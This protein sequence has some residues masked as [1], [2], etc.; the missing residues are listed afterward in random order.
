M[1]N[2]KIGLNV[3]LAIGAHSVLSEQPENERE[4]ILQ[5]EI[6]QL[7][8]SHGIA[9]SRSSRRHYFQALYRTRWHK[10]NIG[11]MADICNN[12]GFQSITFRSLV[13][14]KNHLQIPIDVYEMTVTL[15]DER[16]YNKVGRIEGN[17]VLNVSLHA[18]YS[19][20]GHLFFKP[21]G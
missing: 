13:Q 5:V 4:L 9:V 6:P 8:Y 18:L 1:P 2:T 20:N 11:I 14:I 3:K 10:E 17:G 15:N 21:H 12:F 19:L 7:S 16:N